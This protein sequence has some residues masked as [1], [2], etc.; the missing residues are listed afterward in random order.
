[1]KNYCHLLILLLFSFLFSSFIKPVNKKNNKPNQNGNAGG[2]ADIR[3]DEQRS[4]SIE[5]AR[6]RFLPR[7]FRKNE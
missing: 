3:I 2:S 6:N 5:P 4:F 1:M 7:A